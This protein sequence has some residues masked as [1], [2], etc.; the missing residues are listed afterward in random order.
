MGDTFFIGDT[1]FGHSRILT[2][3]K[4]KPY[5]PFATIEEH[6]EELIKRWN[7]VVRKHDVVWHLGDVGFG[8]A[9][10]ELCGRLN[11]LKKL[12]LGNHDAYSTELY[13]KHFHKVYGAFAWNGFLLTHVPVHPC[14]LSREGFNRGNIHGHLHTEVVM[15]QVDGQD[16]IDERYICVAAEQINLTPISLE[17]LLQRRGRT[18]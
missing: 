17:E 7:S 18:L 3:E 10:V 6:N 11:G 14:Q 5:R 13:L 15:K 16:V 1:H 9:A 12:V 8:K 2:F 4:I